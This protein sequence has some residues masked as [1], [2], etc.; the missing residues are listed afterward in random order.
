MRPE[1]ILA[2]DRIA[3][4]AILLLALAASIVSNDSY[5]LR[6]L[7]VAGCYAILAIGYQRIFG[8]LGVLSLAQGAFFAI[9]GYATAI[10]GQR[11][12]WD[13]LVLLPLA[14]ATATALAVAVAPPML[15]LASHYFALASLAVAQLVLLAAVNLEALTG[16]ANGLSPL[17]PLKIFGWSLEQGRSLTLA[18]WI[19]AALC[20]LAFW[21]PGALRLLRR[22]VLREAPLVA[23]AIGLNAAR[24]RIAAFGF[25]AAC[26]GLA[27]GLYVQAT[28]V[29]APDIAELGIMINVLAMSVIGGR[30]RAAGALIG[31][32]LLAFLP[33]ALRFL[34]GWQ[35]FAWGAAM[36]AILLLAPGGLVGLAEKLLPS[37][38][39][40]T[41]ATS[42]EPQPLPSGTLQAKALGKSFGG[43]T[44]VAG[45]S[46]SLGKGEIVAIIGPN[47]AG[48]TTLLNLL[49]G[50]Q[51]PDGGTIRWNDAEISHDPAHR[52][53]ALGIARSFQTDQ[54]PGEVTALDAIAAATRQASDLQTARAAA[55]ALAKRLGLSEVAH[56]P[57]SDLAPPTRRLVD[58]ARALAISPALLLLDEPTSGLAAA[59]REALAQVLRGLRDEGLSLLLVEHD[60]GFVLSL[61]DRLVC[62]DQGRVAAEGAP[63]DL[64]A[65]PELHRFFGRW[66]R[67]A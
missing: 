24:W 56:L 18:I 34:G 5:I 15:K 65:R 30:G 38:A 20:A 57:L 22:Q 41:I 49:S 23:E 43:V 28:G 50:F 7:A 26:A 31:A 12:G 59:E 16:G 19:L 44:A 55:L 62:L 25:S 35:Y 29:V 60:I 52:R 47:G 64:A 21:L 33:E 66:A 17:P 42:S 46:F 2:F 36:L 4:A 63:Q 8:E 3:S 54:L 67:P 51:R 39:V 48:K 1:R 6:L 11:F 61:A 9:G 53:A 58:I 10:L 14:M 13:G 37:P 27:G 45:I 40:L 32:L